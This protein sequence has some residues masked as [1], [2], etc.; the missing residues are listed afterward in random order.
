M[1]FIECG[2]ISLSFQ[3]RIRS[4]QEQCSW[5]AKRFANRR[6]DFRVLA[7]EWRLQVGRTS[8]CQGAAALQYHKALAQGVPI[9]TGVIEGTCRHLVE[10][11]MNLTGARWS[12]TGAEAV[13]RLRAL[14]SRLIFEGPCIP[15]SLLV[16]G[17][18]MSDMKFAATRE[19]PIKA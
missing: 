11:R 2:C 10:D 9:A 17:F 5:P 16:F 3:S 19:N 14:R 13:L 15:L 6:E 4:R 7:A 18:G 8:E 1:N 12:L